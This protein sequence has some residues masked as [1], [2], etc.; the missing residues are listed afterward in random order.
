MGRT[1]DPISD[2]IGYEARRERWLSRRPVCSDC[3]YPIQGEECYEFDGKLLCSE[4]LRENHLKYTE[5][6]IG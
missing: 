3:G 5:D 6:Y 4:C 1:D 2:H